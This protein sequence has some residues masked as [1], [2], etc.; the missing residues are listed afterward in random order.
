M[1]TACDATSQLLCRCLVVS[2][3]VAQGGMPEGPLAAESPEWGGSRRAAPKTSVTNNKARVLSRPA[4][5]AA[6]W[7][8]ISSPGKMGERRGCCGGSQIHH[9]SGSGRREGEIRKR[10]DKRKERRKREYKREKSGCA[11]RGGQRRRLPQVLKQQF[12]Q[13]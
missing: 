1:R 13:N 11:R 7:C 9:H 2:L 6:V 3:L 8:Q 5:G 12:G 4:C 10:N